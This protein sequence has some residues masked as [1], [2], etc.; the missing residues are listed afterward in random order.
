M[1]YKT[2]TIIR[3]AEWIIE[4]VKPNTKVNREIISRLLH[5]IDMAENVDEDYTDL[6]SDLD[7]LRR[8][9]AK[10]PP[11]PLDDDDD[12]DEEEFD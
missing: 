10:Y 11:M 2:D 7:F 1:T 3:D 8:Q 6:E 4:R 9:Y 5:I 12:Y